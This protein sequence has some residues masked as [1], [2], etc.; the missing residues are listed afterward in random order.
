MSLVAERD[1][2]TNKEWRVIQSHPTPAQ[3]QRYLRRLPYNW[4]RD[5]ETLRSFRQV[6]RL[7][8][9]HCL[10][11]ALVAAVI[12]EQHGFPPLLMSLESQD[13]L[14]HVIF[15]FRK[16][17][18]WG[19]VARSR[20]LG[21][22]GRRPVYRTVRQL[23]WSYFDPYVDLT[24]RVTGYGVANLCALGNYDWRFSKRNMWKV[25]RHL[26]DMPHRPLKSSDRR[27][28]SLVARYQTFKSLHPDEPVTHFA[29]KN[30]WLL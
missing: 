19:A 24:A 29:N 7:N 4:E 27:Y 9:A 11:A 18:L 16:K 30:H 26:I 12:L 1:A 28:R 17:G 21:L 15:I 20:D 22:H 3:V 13:E 10:E 2:F 6:V 8:T 25:E 14:D 5:G 23:A